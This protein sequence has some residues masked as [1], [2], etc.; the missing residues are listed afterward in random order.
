MGVGDERQ[1]ADGPQVVVD[2]VGEEVVR[3]VSEDA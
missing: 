1:R 3:A 2:R